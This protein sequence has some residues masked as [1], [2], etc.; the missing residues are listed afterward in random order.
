MTETE[1]TKSASRH[2][3]LAVARCSRA[4][5]LASH[6]L[7][8]FVLVRALVK[9]ASKTLA[10]AWC[11]C[12]VL[13]VTSVI[14]ATKRGKFYRVPYCTEIRLNSKEAFLQQVPVGLQVE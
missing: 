4:P 12:L 8:L 6:P 13:V 9:E 7:L 5:E 2:A 10:Q 3:S 11:S 1:S 14:E